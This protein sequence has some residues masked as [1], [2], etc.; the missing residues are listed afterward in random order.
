MMHFS[1]LTIA[2]RWHARSFSG[3]RSGA[4]KGS[5]STEFVKHGLGQG[6]HIIAPI[7]TAIGLVS[8]AAGSL[9]GMG[10][11]FVS[12]PLVEKIFRLSQHQLH[13]T[14]LA[15]V[16]ATSVGGATG[17]SQTGSV[18]W[19]TA[20]LLAAGAGVGVLVGGRVAAQMEPLALK[21]LLGI[22]MISVS[23]LVIVQGRLKQW[24]TVKAVAEK[25]GEDPAGGDGAARGDTLGSMLGVGFASGITSGLFGVG[26]GAITVPGLTVSGHPYTTALG[27][28]LAAMVIP[29]VI[30]ATLQH[31]KGNVVWRVAGPLALGSFLGCQFG[32]SYIAVN[33]DEDVLRI[34]FS[35]LMLG[36]GLRAFNA[37]KSAAI[38]SSF[39]RGGGSV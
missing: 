36:L 6:S 2:S 5:R 39:K 4:G 32:G 10:G 34:L 22:F 8:G 9:V 18:D 35:G 21:K 17:F 37:A 11:A 29:T 15:A 31:I 30:G 20:G 38:L 23:P 12:L 26:G 7:A 1:R 28:S 19:K 24:S 33:V 14:S 27:T 16:A 13:A 25:E 3:G